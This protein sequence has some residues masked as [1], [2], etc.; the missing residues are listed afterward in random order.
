VRVLAEPDLRL[1]DFHVG[2]EPQ[3]L[4]FRISARVISGEI[5]DRSNADCVVTLTAWRP[6]W[7]DDVRWERLCAAHEVEVLILREKI[8]AA[9]PSAPGSRP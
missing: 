2:S 4:S 1:V 6:A 8:E 3:S 9:A 5:L 7:M